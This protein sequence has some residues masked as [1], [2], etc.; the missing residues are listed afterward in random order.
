MSTLIMQGIVLV[1]GL[2]LYVAIIIGCLWLRD[3]IERM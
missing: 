1:G 3:E 2:A